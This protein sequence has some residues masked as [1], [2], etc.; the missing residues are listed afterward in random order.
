M[1]APNGEFTFIL[2]EKRDRNGDVYLFGGLQ[3]MNMVLFI[4]PEPNDEFKRWKAVLKP[5]TPKPGKDDEFG[6]EE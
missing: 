2:R 1:N 3:F 6:W 5:Y 4:R